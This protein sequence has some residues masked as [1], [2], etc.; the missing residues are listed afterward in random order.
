M[1]INAAV[2]AADTAKVIADLPTTILWRN[3]TI[4]CTA[5]DATDGNELGEFGLNTVPST[6]FIFLLAAVVG[7]RKPVAND[8]VDW[9]GRALRIS[10][11]TISP[12]GTTMTI[13]T[14]NRNK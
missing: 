3:Q 8:N 13:T 6:Q 11:T 2:F 7:E 10:A 5:S 9:N 12:C 4:L 14:V 1:A